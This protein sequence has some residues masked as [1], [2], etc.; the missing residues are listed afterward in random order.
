MSTC[1]FLETP[2]CADIIA[3]FWVM[4]VKTQ[5]V[6]NQQH[7]CFQDI[8]VS[9]YTYLFISIHDRTL[10]IFK[11]SLTCPIMP[12]NNVNTQTIFMVLF[13]SRSL[14][15]W[16][17]PLDASS[18]ISPRYLPTTHSQLTIPPSFTDTQWWQIMPSSLRGQTGGERRWPCCGG[19][20]P[21]A[22]HYNNSIYPL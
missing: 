14:L 12:I 15:T 18:G 16:E 20:S 1:A 13:I 4:W 19:A 8:T 11:L 21:S 17:K 10:L 7:W 22:T 5:N 9:F 6:Q 2:P 3:S